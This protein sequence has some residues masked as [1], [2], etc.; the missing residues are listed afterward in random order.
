MSTEF[1]SLERV[2]RA[3]AYEL[4][5]KVN[6]IRKDA[7]NA[8][9]QAREQAIRDSKV[10]I[11]QIRQE[12]IQREQQVIQ[13]LRSET[14]NKLAQQDAQHRAALLD[15]SGALQNQLNQQAGDFRNRLNDVRTQNQNDINRLRTETNNLI[16][17][18]ASEV[19][20]A[21]EIQN[22]VNRNH[23]AQINSVKND[24]RN[25]Q[26]NITDQISWA[27]ENLANCKSNISEM[28]N[29]IAINR[30]QGQELERVKKSVS[31]AETLIASAPQA[32]IGNLTEARLNLM[33]IRE[34]AQISQAIFESLFEQ[35]LSGIKSL[36]ENIK[37]NKANTKTRDTNVDLIFWTNGKYTDFEEKV[38][39]L[40]KEVSNAMQ[41]PALKIDGLTDIIQNISILEFEE[42]NL[43]VEAV[44]NI[45][46]SH[47]RNV[48][49]DIAINSLLDANFIIKKEDDEGYI[50]QDF[51]EGYYATLVNRNN[52]GHCVT[53]IVDSVFDEKNNELKNRLDI[54]SNTND[55]M[56]MHSMEGYQQ[57]LSNAMELAG[58]D[59]KKL[60]VED[61]KVFDA[62]ALKTTKLNNEQKQRLKL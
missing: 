11:N 7:A 39:N 53:V 47:N 57:I 9:N 55:I 43:V 14:N 58:G 16:N 6:Q 18:L 5:N 54:Q 34:K 25:L 19:N 44:R 51:R 22:E 56:D 61:V 20:N 62:N 4:Q 3:A 15:M 50:A 42:E 59:V 48:I 26:Q 8:A 33:E 10:K 49:A 13:T 24:V 1:K 41:N 21:F 35:S 29:D 60:N 31:N 45:E 17:N 12:T 52:E 36:V 38:S 28:E 40:E 23:Q 37:H 2:D 32:A 27:K 46:L 30:F